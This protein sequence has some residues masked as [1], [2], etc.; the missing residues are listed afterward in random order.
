[1]S[2]IFF[3]SFKSGCEKLRGKIT[4]AATTGPAK[5]PLPASSQPASTKSVVKDFFS[6]LILFTTSIITS[7][8]HKINRCHENK[9]PI[10][11]QPLAC[12]LRLTV[13]LDE[14]K[15]PERRQSRIKE[16]Y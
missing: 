16:D 9:L 8:F 11:G 1:R 14:P 12:E 2:V 10:L 5:Q 4:A 6:R 15:H 3:E 13:V 7:F